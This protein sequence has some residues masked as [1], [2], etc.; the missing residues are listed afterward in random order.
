[1]KIGKQA[2]LALCIAAGVATLLAAPRGAAAADV[3]FEIGNIYAV[4]NDP[5]NVATVRL[6]ARSRVTAIST[7]HWNNAKG[8]PPGTIALMNQAGDMFGP[9]QAAGRPGQG[10]VPNA[11][12]VVKLD[13]ELQAGEYD[14]IDSEVE[15]WAH[16]RESGGVGFVRVEGR[17]LAE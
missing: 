10:G 2:R 15:T 9:W 1:M 16:N 14:V 7:Y 8:S 3:L 13:I 5:P 6:D 17:R 11:Y 4:A 12:W